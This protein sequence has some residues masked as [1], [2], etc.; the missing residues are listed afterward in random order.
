MTYITVKTKETKANIEIYPPIVLNEG[1]HI[2]LV[3][4]KIPEEV[5]KSF[6]FMGHQA[7]S[8]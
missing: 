6:S 2:S 1:S 7:I 8:R 5:T 3:D 4:I